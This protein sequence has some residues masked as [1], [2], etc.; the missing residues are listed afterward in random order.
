MTALDDRIAV[1][2]PVF[3]V[4]HPLDDVPEQKVD[5]DSL[6]PM[7]MTR[8]VKI[9]LFALRGYLFVMCGLLFFRVV[10]LAGA[11]HG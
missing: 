1:E 9:S 5:T 8:T 11:I 7:P 2:R 4:V 6:G 10:Q 3:F